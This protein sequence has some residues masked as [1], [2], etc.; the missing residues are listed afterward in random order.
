MPLPGTVVD[1][2]GLAY[3]L[4]PRAA[5]ARNSAPQSLE[6]VQVFDRAIR[7]ARA[8]SWIAGSG[9]APPLRQRDACGYWK[10]RIISSR[11]S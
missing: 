9:T 7:P 8:Y 5:A 2:C 3:R 10:E 11:L 6:K 4:L 1:T